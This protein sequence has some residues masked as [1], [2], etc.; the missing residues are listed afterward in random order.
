ML[1]WWIA[2]G[3]SAGILSGMFGIGGGIALIPFLTLGLKYPQQAANGTSLVALLFPVGIFAV[4]TYYRAG[5]IGVEE[6]KAGS[7]IA[8]VMLLTTP[9]GAYLALKLPE[10]WLRRAFCFLL[11]YVAFKL[12]FKK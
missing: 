1:L 12:W 4:L 11:I 2:A 5:K 7:A 3:M 9:I 10:L 8:L 6:L